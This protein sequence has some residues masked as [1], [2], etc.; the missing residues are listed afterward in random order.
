MKPGL[1]GTRGKNR[2]RSGP[3]QQKK[4]KIICL[5]KANF[6]LTKEKKERESHRDKRKPKEEMEH[7]NP[8]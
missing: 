7:R 3:F 4:F 6:E 2:G 8:A 1:L 5:L